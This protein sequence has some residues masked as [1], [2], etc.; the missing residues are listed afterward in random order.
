MLTARI[1]RIIFP[2]LALATASAHADT[3]NLSWDN[4]LLIGLDE[5]YTNGVRLSYLTSPASNES[6]RS[7]KVARQA[8]NA[9][10]A[11][12]GIHHSE[13][14]QA[15]A[16]SLRQLM[17]TPEDISR[18]QP[19][20][21]DLPYAGYLSL[22][23]T[24]WSWGGDTITGYGAHVGVVGPESGA[25]A[26][27][28]WVH[29]LTGSEEPKGWDHQLGTDVVGGIQATHARKL[30][31]RGEKGELEQQLSWVGAGMLS[32]FRS[33]GRIG[34]VWRI[35]RYLP[36]NFIPD[37]AGTSSTIGIPAAVNG[38]GQGWSVFLG[39]GVE[40]VAYSYLEENAGP[41]QFKQSPWLL[42][43]GLGATWQWQ[44]LQTAF[45]L[46]ATTGEEESNKD[47]FSFGT[48]SL[49]WTY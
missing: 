22:S 10:S 21:N 30:W 12:P 6:S 20:E 23:S 1:A 15:V 42:Q 49:T 17:V 7:A 25:E 28:K 33:H 44:N 32:S 16:V 26:S 27:Q 47:D 36:A 48:L 41:Y 24:L 40:Y 19:S 4:D 11:W 39:L 2:G 29:K 13:Q 18:E 31:Q 34:G 9:F 46:R 35:G 45:I 38:A 3:F 37:Y 8:A 14:E 5:G 43:A